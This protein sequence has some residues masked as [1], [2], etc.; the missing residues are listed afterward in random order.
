MISITSLAK[1]KTYI[2]IKAIFWT[3]A[4]LYLLDFYKWIMPTWGSTVAAAIVNITAFVAISETFIHFQAVPNYFRQAKY[5]TFLTAIAFCILLNG[6]VTLFGTWFVI[7]PISP[8]SVNKMVGKWSGLVFSNFFVVA[9]FTATSIAAKLM[10]DW[11]SL[12][13]QMEELEKEKVK[14]ELEFLKS[15]INP[16][17]LF[18]S[19]NLI[20]GKID[21]R[22]DSAR[23]LLLKFSDVLRYQLYE[24]NEDFVPVEREIEFLESYVEV[25]KMR[26]SEKIAVELEMSGSFS[27]YKIAPLLFIPFVENAFKYVSNHRNKENFLR[28]EVTE[29]PDFVRFKCVNTIENLQTEDLAAGASSGI[30]INNVRRR[31]ELLYPERHRLVQEKSDGHFKIDLTLFL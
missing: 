12:Q 16:H 23:T 22:N 9:A 24:C 26:K 27:G 15:Q 6:L 1:Q 7:Q 5:K 28:I 17:F 21:K 14:A 3:I 30:G 18:N 10:F 20:Y 11:L 2:V 31:L 4:F 19:L 8:D 13:K 25:Q 29:E